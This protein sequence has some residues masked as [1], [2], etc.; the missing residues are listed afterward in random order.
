M[1]QQAQTNKEK[2]L[3]QE[4]NKLKKQIKSLQKALEE[5]QKFIGGH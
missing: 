3:L 4:N 1:E 2:Q 5:L